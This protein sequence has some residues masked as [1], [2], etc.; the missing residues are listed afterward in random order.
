MEKHMI[1]RAIVLAA[2]SGRRM[3]SDVPKQFLE[4]N[5]RPVLSY[6]LAAFQNHPD[7][8]EIVLVTSAGYMTFCEEQIVKPFRFDKVKHIVPGGKERTDSVYEGLLAA[9]ECDYVLIHDGARPF[10]TGEMID[11]CIEGAVKHGAAVAA[12]PSKDTVKLSDENGFVSETP[13]RNYVW[14]IQTPQA[15]SYPLV[16]KAHEEMYR[17]GLLGLTDD[18]SVVE[19]TTGIKVKLVEGSYR[20][21]KITTQEDMRIA[22]ALSS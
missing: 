1:C 22:A 3:H 13:D 2:G 19:R 12:V 7:I 5:G 20:N 6:S 8:D 14:T 15:F 4:L 9:G 18:A 10:L 21:I 11:R 17:Q 16:L